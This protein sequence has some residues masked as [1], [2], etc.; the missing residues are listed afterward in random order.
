MIPAWSAA[1]IDH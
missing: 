1:G